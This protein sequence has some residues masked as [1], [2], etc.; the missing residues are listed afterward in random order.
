MTTTLTDLATGR[1]FLIE[2]ALPGRDAYEEAVAR[3]FVGDRDA[4]LASLRGFAFDAIDP[5][6][7]PD[8]TYVA[9]AAVRFDN[10][11]WVAVAAN[12]GVTPGTDPAI[13]LMLFDGVSPSVAEALDRANHTG[14]QAASTISDL[15]AIATSGSA[16]D[17]GSGTLPA[18]RFDDTAHGNRAGGALHAAATPSV[19]GF[20]SAGDKT[21][22]D[23]I[24]AGANAYTHPNHT[25]DVTSTGDG[26]TAIAANAVTN[27][28]LADMPPNTVKV[29]AAGTSGDPSDL[30]LGASQ[31]LGR[32]A[33]GDVAP[34]ALGTG[35][36]MTGA[37]LNA[38]GL[39]DMLKTV[40][41]PTNISGSAFARENH[42]GTQSASTITGLATVATSGSAA[43]LGAGILPAARFN[44]TAHGTRGGANLHT[45]ATPT[46]AG[47][48]SSAD[49]SKLD[50]IAAGANAYTHPN[51]TGDVTSTGDGATTIA[52]NAVNNTKLADMATAR[53]KGRVTAG[54][55]D[56]EDLTA[57]EVRTMLN[58]A[59][60]RELDATARR[61][62]R[63]SRMARPRLQHGH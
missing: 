52:A 51:H 63:H 54:T 11:L 8:R 13:W 23:G 38:T 25:G 12:T 2:G 36:T 41:D 1:T 33:T 55:G 15:A 18:A 58:V 53:I 26:A 9:N 3:G 7:A 57:A 42:T 29:R 48:M 37:T 10:K 61:L 20:M 16:S 27:A 35:L 19:A 60:P 56:P 50:G 45:A 14:T 21:K 62:L 49:K 59:D 4:W 24:A 46:N 47:F 30:A 31:L 5:D 28:K 17:L 6:W 40:Y 43:D 22:L 32:G 39:G 44:D 34:I